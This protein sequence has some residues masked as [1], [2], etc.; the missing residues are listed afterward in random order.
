[1]GEHVLD[2][3][4]CNHVF[5]SV[6]VFLLVIFFVHEGPLAI[7]FTVRSRGPGIADPIDRARDEKCSHYLAECHREGW[8]FRVWGADTHG[9]LDKESRS[10]TKKLIERVKQAPKFEDDSKVGRKSGMPCPRPHS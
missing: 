1:M 5:A 8:A 4:D 10:L 7:D 3:T 9:A 6:F 2:I